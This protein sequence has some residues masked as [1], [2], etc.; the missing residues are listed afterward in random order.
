MVGSVLGWW[1]RARCR[2]VTISARVTDWSGQYRGGPVAHPAVISRSASCSTWRIRHWPSGMSPKRETPTT[3]AS[4][5][6]TRISHMSIVNRRMGSW[7]QNSPSPHPISTKWSSPHNIVRV[8]AAT[9]PQSARFEPRAILRSFRSLVPHLR[10]SALLAG[11]GPSGSTG[12]S[13]RCQSCSPPSP[14]FHRVQAAHSFNAPAATSTQ[15]WHPTTA[16]LENASWRSM[17]ASHRRSVGVPP[18][19]RTFPQ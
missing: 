7:G 6:R 2:K 16:R 3:G 4:P 14:P 13:R 9:R 19:S 15:R 12:P 8:C 1:F 10:L 17:S 11:P 18:S 5:P